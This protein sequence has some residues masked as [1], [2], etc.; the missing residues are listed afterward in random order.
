MFAVLASG[1][2]AGGYSPLPCNPR[3]NHPAVNGWP[4]YCER[5][6]TREEIIAW[7]KIPEADVCLACGF[8]GLVAVDLDDDRPELSAERFLT[9]R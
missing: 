5:Q 4:D 1:F 8:G 7:A 6:A 2:I 3:K 9:G